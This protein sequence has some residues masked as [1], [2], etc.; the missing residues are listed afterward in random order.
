MSP[1]C[2][3]S[4]GKAE[5][6][7]TRVL[8][9]RNPKQT[10]GDPFPSLV[11]PNCA[12]GVIVLHQSAIGPVPVPDRIALSLVRRDQ[13]HSMDVIP[14]MKSLPLVVALDVLCVRRR[15]C[16]DRRVGALPKD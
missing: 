10:C 2:P 6:I 15:D 5:D 16:W 3:L 8:T 1:L 13:E 11:M 14:Q 12:L 4:R 7:Y 9:V